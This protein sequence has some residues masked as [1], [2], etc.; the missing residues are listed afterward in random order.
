MLLKS[1]NLVN[2]VGL[3]KFSTTFRHHWGGYSK[4]LLIS[5]GPPLLNE[6]ACHMT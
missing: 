6:F 4:G 5:E 2:D 1:I 3:K